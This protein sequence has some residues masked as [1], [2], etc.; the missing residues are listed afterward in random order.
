MQTLAYF[1]ALLASLLGAILGN[2]LVALALRTL[3]FNGWSA[4]VPF[5]PRLAPGSIGLVQQS[6]M[7][8]GRG[9]VAILIAA[10]TVSLF[11]LPLLP[12]FAILV[13]TVLFLFDIGFILR[14]AG[15][16]FSIRP[17]IWIVFGLGGSI[18]GALL[19]VRP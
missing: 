18:L 5:E 13:I 10:L 1:I 11:R 3:Q 16:Y 2:L 7:S 17:P 15:N 6:I 19:L 14:R 9:F 8:F 12:G 4:P